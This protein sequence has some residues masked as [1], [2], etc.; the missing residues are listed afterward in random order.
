[1]VKE[2]IPNIVSQGESFTVE[3]KGEEKSPLSDYELYKAVACLANGN[4]GLLLIDLC[5]LPVVYMSAVPLWERASRG[6][7]PFMHMKWTLAGGVLV[8]RT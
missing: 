2:E 5:V 4:G 8:S 6:A 7:F 1:M 3:F